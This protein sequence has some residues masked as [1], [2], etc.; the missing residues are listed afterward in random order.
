MASIITISDWQNT[1]STLSRNRLKNS[2]INPFEWSAEIRVFD[3]SAVRQQCKIEVVFEGF[4]DA[5]CENL[6]SLWRF[7]FL[8]VPIQVLNS[9]PINKNGINKGSAKLTLAPIYE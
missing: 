1:F 5:L 2:R 7:K 4:Y 9:F 8:F 3:W 6:R